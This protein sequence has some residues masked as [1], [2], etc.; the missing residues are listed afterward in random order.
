LF[1]PIE[2]GREDRQHDE[3]STEAMSKHWFRLN[4]I[5]VPYGIILL[6]CH[7]AS[8]QRCAAKVR[9]LLNAEK[10]AHR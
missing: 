1:S 3:D 8:A 9:W 5:A 6:D 4:V 10:V 2:R 7:V